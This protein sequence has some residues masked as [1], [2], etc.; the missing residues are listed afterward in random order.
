ML[1]MRELLRKGSHIAL[2]ISPIS[3]GRTTKA[4]TTEEQRCLLFDTL[5]VN[6]PRESGVGLSDGGGVPPTRRNERVR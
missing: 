1:G 6:A 3:P 5:S 2:V 4:R